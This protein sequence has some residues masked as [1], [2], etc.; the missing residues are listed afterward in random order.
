MKAIINGRAIVP[1]ADGNFI[2]D[3]RAAIAFDDRII[4]TGATVDG[5]DVIDANGNFIA[6]GF[7]NVHIHGCAGSDAMDD[8]SNALST[9]KNFLPSTGVTSFL[10][11]TMTMSIEKIHH[12]LENIRRE[13]SKGGGAKILGAHVEGPFISKK[14]K[15]AQDENNI[16][17]ADFSLI[18]PFADVIKIVTIAP[19]ELTDFHFIDQCRQ[20]GIIVSIGHSA[21]DY[22]TAIKAIE[23]GARHITHLF[24]A[25]TGL[26]HRRPGIVGSALDSNAIVE[27]IADNVHIAPAVQ[28]I[29]SKIKPLNEIILIT[30]SLRACGCGDGIFELGGQRVTV[31]GNVATLDDGTI[32]ASV[33]PMN[34]V[35]KNFCVNSQLPM[36]NVIECV[37][38]TP[39]VE[40]GLY[41]RIGSIEVG[42]AADLIIF[43]DAL[44]IQAAFV[45][46]NLFGRD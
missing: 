17:R 16:L 30:D 35:V 37:T 43:D 28:R 32:A 29:V 4:S 39:A 31:K 13:M 36:E 10:P 23:N 1:D 26:H 41:D 18:E 15:G 20:R 3:N 40:L 42:K 45:D 6:P 25:Q 12:A 5:C 11:T 8:D 33:A 14:F 7:I 24:N 34:A 22:Q 44:N 9:M 2:I 21:A 46:G 27:L 38:K 19:E